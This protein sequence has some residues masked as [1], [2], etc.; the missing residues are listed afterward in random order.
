L[1]RRAC[2]DHCPGGRSA[3]IEISNHGGRSACVPFLADRG[4]SCVPV[5]G[6]AVKGGSFRP[7]ACSSPSSRNRGPSRN[8]RNAHCGPLSV[9]KKKTKRNPACQ[10][11]A[12]SA[13]RRQRTPPRGEWRRPITSKQPPR[14]TPDECPHFLLPV[15]YD[16]RARFKNKTRLLRFFEKSKI[17][18]SETGFHFCKSNDPKFDFGR[19]A[20]QTKSQ[21]PNPP[22]NGKSYNYTS[23]PQT[24]FWVGINH[25]HPPWPGG[26]RPA[27]AAW[28]MRWGCGAWAPQGLLLVE[29][30]GCSSGARLFETSGPRQQTIFSARWATVPDPAGTPGSGGS[31]L[32]D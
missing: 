20:D 30:T 25:E 13:L 10:I 24:S 21:G 17:F 31:T 26:G 19:K 2:P 15:K 9:R 14:A 28:I 12:R 11:P 23:R 32:E 5:Q 7:S 27:S 22:P 29:A 16:D 8:F 18:F 4:C 1:C 6:L 3:A